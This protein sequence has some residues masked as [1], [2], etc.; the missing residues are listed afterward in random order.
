MCVCALCVCV[1]ACA[2][3]Q[4][5]TALSMNFQ[6]FM[7]LPVGVGQSTRCDSSCIF[8]RDVSRCPSHQTQYQD[9][10]SV[11][12]ALI[13]LRGNRKVALHRVPLNTAAIAGCTGGYRLSMRYSF[14]AQWHDKRDSLYMA[15][16]TA[17]CYYVYFRTSVSV[18][19]IRWIAVGNVCTACSVVKQPVSR[20]T[21]YDIMA[22]WW[23]TCVVLWLLCCWSYIHLC[24]WTKLRAPTR[25]SCDSAQCNEP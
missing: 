6:V 9:E 20:V 5:L 22:L 19:P 11:L 1:R 8:T 21:F 3:L 16:F 10:C 18:C 25:L 7:V 12:T 17:T 4:A 24:R 13:N 2:R 15:C 14:R 23:Q